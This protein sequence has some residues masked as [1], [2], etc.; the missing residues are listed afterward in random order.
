MNDNQIP[1]GYLPEA[2]RKPKAP[3]PSRSDEPG[4]MNYTPD[5]TYVPGF[6]SFLFL[7][8]ACLN[9]MA[10]IAGM[11]S[12]CDRHWDGTD[13]CSPRGKWGFVFP[14][15]TVGAFAR[16][17]FDAP[18]LNPFKPTSHPNYTVDFH[19]SGSGSVSYSMSEVIIGSGGVEVPEG[20]RATKMYLTEEKTDGIRK[21][22]SDP[23]RS[24]GKRTSKPA[25]GAGKYPAVTN[26]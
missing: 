10:F 24:A 7:G 16:T 3:L 14:G 22:K 19:G 12:G 15:Y 23:G 25:S 20:Y 11:L 9:I 6:F 1:E 5:E 13:R 18:E 4:A 26:Y 2:F 17:R 21:Q 8:F